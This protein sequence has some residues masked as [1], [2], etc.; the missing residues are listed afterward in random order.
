MDIPEEVAIPNGYYSNVI[1][2][3]QIYTDSCSA[4]SKR[5]GMTVGVDG[6]VYESKSTSASV[7]WIYNDTAIRG[8]LHIPTTGVT[9]WYRARGKASS[10]E[11]TG[12]SSVYDH[13]LL[14]HLNGASGTAPARQYAINACSCNKKC[15]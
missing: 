1:M 6:L 14:Y 9:M 12:F 2:G 13:E 10:F 7:N 11:V 5:D 4:S 15:G 8:V 3:S